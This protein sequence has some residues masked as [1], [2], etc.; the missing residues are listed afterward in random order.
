M[1]FCFSLYDIE[2]DIYLIARDHMGICPL[3]QGWDKSGNYYI[4]SELKA[5]EGVCNKIE[6]FLPGH[7][8]YSKDGQELQQ[9]YKRDWEDFDAVKDNETDIAAIRKGLEEAVHRQMMSDV[10]YGVLLS[11]GLDSSIIS[12]VAAKYAKK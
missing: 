7:F 6:T 10:P 4:A 3:Y 5:L 1:D 12:A 11:G 9:W 8:V 2:N